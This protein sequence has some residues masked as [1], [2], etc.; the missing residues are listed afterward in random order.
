[1]WFL[2]PLLDVVIFLDT[3]WFLIFCIF[4]LLCSAGGCTQQLWTFHGIKF[5]MK[6]WNGPPN[7]N[8]EFSVLPWYIFLYCISVL[9]LNL[10]GKC[11][12][13]CPCV[14]AEKTVKY[15]GFSRYNSCFGYEG[16]I[17][18]ML[19]VHLRASYSFIKYHGY[20]LAWA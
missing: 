12:S 4:G 18:L 20:H 15:I 5:F 14:K 11:S 16:E 9:L 1:M 7:P 19:S 3:L 10:V 6:K 2:G 8:L 17:V 13:L